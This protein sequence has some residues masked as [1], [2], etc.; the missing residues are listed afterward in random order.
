MRHNFSEG[1]QCE[2]RVNKSIGWVR[3]VITYVGSVGMFSH[4]IV[5]TQAHGRFA[6]SPGHEDLRRIS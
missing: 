5:D 2:L 3:G 4:Y 1:E 6:V